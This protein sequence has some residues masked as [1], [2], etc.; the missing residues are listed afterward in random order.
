MTLQTNGALLF[1][2]H[3]E[4][5][6]DRAAFVF[7]EEG[8]ERT[9]T[10][11]EHHDAM[12]RIASGL[13][14]AGL[15]TGARVL[16]SAPPGPQLLWA[17]Y[18]TIRAGLTAVMCDPAMSGSGADAFLRR[19]DCSAAIVGGTG[20]VAEAVGRSALPHRF[21]IGD[22]TFDDL[23]AATPVELP[24][25][26]PA[27]HPALAYSTSGSTGEP[28]L[29]IKTHEHLHLLAR[30][31]SGAYT[32]TTMASG[33][34]ATRY[35]VATSLYHTSGLNAGVMLGLLRGWTGV[36]A[37]SFNPGKILHKL[38]RQRC[39]TVIFTP[40]Q[41]AVLLRERELLASLDFGAL[42]SVRVGSGPSTPELLRR[43]QAALPGAEVLN[44]YALTECAPCLGQ[45]PG[46]KQP[47][48]SCGRPWAGVTARVLDEAG[49]EVSEGELWIKSDLISEGTILD[50]ETARDRYVD[51]WLRTRDIFRVDDDGW[52]HFVGRADDMFVCGGENVYPGEVERILATHPDV[53]DVC[54]VG[55]PDANL[56]AVPAAAVALRQGS[57]ATPADL[58][59]FVRERAAIHLVPQRIAVVGRIPTLGPGKVDRRQ[60]RQ[61]LLGAPG[62]AAPVASASTDPIQEQVTQIWKEVMEVDEV[63][64][65]VSFFDAGGTS[66]LALEM[67]A[68]LNEINITVD[69]GELFINGSVDD[70]VRL[71]AEAEE[72]ATV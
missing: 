52:Y 22:R 30:Y 29:V 47:L 66:S 3:V 35:L 10:Y 55:L 50:E 33:D 39:A 65:T 9:V 70:I 72:T 14:A 15:E 61:D 56:G 58:V 4:A 57:T 26:V 54:V 59:A 63:D 8:D 16:I 19:A 11:A 43:L 67:A 6:P 21:T 7:G 44:I 13:V 48:A 24:E 34:D 32:A 69:I 31:R 53:V 17:V 45:P 49:R 40:S 2:D 37:D 5:A 28:K 25:E 64:P 36:I 18:G 60:V 46:E 27:R 41:A 51:G 12:T 20:A 71:V 62:V 1:R 23:V 42:R 68:R 38:S